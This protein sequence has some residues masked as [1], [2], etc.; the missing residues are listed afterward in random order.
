MFWEKFEGES[1]KDVF[2]RQDIKLEQI[3]HKRLVDV[4]H[5]ESLECWAKQGTFSSLEN[6]NKELIYTMKL[7]VVSPILNDR[8]LQKLFPPIYNFCV[9][10]NNTDKRGK[11]VEEAN[12]IGESAWWGDLAKQIIKEKTDKIFSVK[13][14]QELYKKT[15]KDIQNVWGFSDVEIDAFRYF[16]C[17]TRHENHNPSL[18]KS[19]YLFSGKK[20][21]GKTS[22]ARAIVSVCNGGKSVA[23]GIEFE[24]NFNQELQIGNHDLP[25][26]SKYNCVMLDEAMPRDSRKTYGLIKSMLTSNKCIYNQKYGRIIPL[27]AK[28]YYIYTSNN[29]ISEFIQDDSE[30]RFIQIDMTRK[31]RYLD[32]PEIYDIWKT[33]AQNCEPENSWQDW[34]D[35]F[36]DI[37]GMERKDM[38][39][40]KD[41]L[42]TN[43]S[44]IEAINN[45]FE[46]TI[47][48]KFFADILITGKPTRDERKT[49]HNAIV[50]LVGEPNGY[51][52]SRAVVKEQL[53]LKSDEM[54]ADD[55]TRGIEE[56]E[57]S[58]PFGPE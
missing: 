10:S 51:R 28:R 1:D 7:A 18:N 27:E 2:M 15:A 57:D 13:P 31:P 41:E 33:F 44:I 6:L 25:F 19:L 52:W 22:I 48:L 39:Y 16:I 38:T 24:S 43:K 47:T 36:E 14:C 46:S 12:N 58:L 42:L 4:A 50:E 40:F 37:D 34:Y 35:T 9:F 30:R 23:D 21:T 26:A 3:P 53:E 56:V 49:L 29:D 54:K 55:I 32:F 8:D 11:L 5:A 45:K 20:K 17:Q